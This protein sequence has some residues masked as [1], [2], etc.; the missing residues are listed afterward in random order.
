MLI[1]WQRFLGAAAGA[2]GRSKPAFPAFSVAVCT[3]VRAQTIQKYCSYGFGE[4]K[5]SAGGTACQ[6][7][8]WSRTL[9]VAP[10]L[11]SRCFHQLWQLCLLTVKGKEVSRQAAHGHAAQ[12][13]KQGLESGN[14]TH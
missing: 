5:S 14:L 3:C 9:P 1:W 13:S 12:V 2:K 8:R 10:P 11:S 4:K 7:H 6:T